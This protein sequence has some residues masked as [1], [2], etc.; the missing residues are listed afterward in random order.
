MIEKYNELAVPRAST[1]LTVQ[2][3]GWWWYGDNLL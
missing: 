3:T 1:P 2:E